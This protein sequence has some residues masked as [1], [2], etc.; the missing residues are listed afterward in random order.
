MATTY[1]ALESEKKS[2][3]IALEKLLISHLRGIRV[4]GEKFLRA[5]DDVW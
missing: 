2:Y 5:A 4:E 1:K 3:K